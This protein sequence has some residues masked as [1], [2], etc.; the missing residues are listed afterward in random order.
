M[1]NWI[2]ETDRAHPLDL[3]IANAGISAGSGGAGESDA[4]TR[5]IFATN[6]DGVLNTVLPAIPLMGARRRGHIAVMSSLAGFRGLPSAPAYSAS[7]ATVR[8]WGEALR[9]QLA[10]DRIG[11]SVICPG[12]VRTPMTSGNRFPMPLLMDA[13][14]AARIIRNGLDRQ[15]ARIA[16]PFPLYCVVQLLQALPPAW[17]DRI[18]ARL[19]R[20]LATIDQL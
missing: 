9:G 7:K 13:A 18:V 20:K 10:A 15:R 4:Q 19:P 17:T 11:V 14:R 8:V 3:V 6:V 5:A 16:F 2:V 1:A 12:Y